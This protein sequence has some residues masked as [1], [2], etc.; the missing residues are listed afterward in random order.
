MAVA[1]S[2]T[3]LNNCN[4][5]TATKLTTDLL[6]LVFTK[7]ELATSSMTGKVGNM[8]LGKITNTKM[9]LDV[10]KVAAVKCK[11]L[12]NIRIRLV[13]FVILLSSE[14]KT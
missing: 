12:S 5:T 4:H 1:V 11:R 2:S 9:Q 7:K 3:K 14:I 6:S 13:L 10:A 8:H